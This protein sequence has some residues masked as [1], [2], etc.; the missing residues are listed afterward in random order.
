MCRSCVC[1]CFR[2]R[3]LFLSCVVRGFCA[4]FLS[5]RCV[6]SGLCGLCAIGAVYMVCWIFSTGW[7]ENLPW[8]SIRKFSCSCFSRVC[9]ISLDPKFL[10]RNAKTRAWTSWYWI[11]TLARSLSVR[12][13]F[14]RAVITEIHG[15]RATAKRRPAAPHCKDDAPP[16]TDWGHRHKRP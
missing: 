6:Q 8:T 7:F 4:V 15:K 3:W 16:H 11:R 2:A 9:P 10:M 1:A 5:C 12:M 14:R 13:R